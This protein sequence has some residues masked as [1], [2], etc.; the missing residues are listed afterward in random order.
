MEFGCSVCEYTSFKKDN[1]IKHINRRK[2]CGSGIKEIIE[3]P[4]EIKCDFCNKNF[5]NMSNCKAHKKNNCKEKDRIKDE[6]I[7]RLKNELK[8]A[9]N[10][11]NITNNNTINATITINN[12]LDTKIDHLTDKYYNK[13]LTN[14]E[15]IHQIIPLII[16][17]IH[18]DPNV[19]ENHNIY[20]SNR[21][22]NNKHLQIF[23]NGHW[24]LANKDTEIDN[25]IND[26]ETNLS[27]WITKKG[28][29]YPEALEKLNEYLDQKFDEEVAKLVKEEVA[30]VLY[31]NRHMIRG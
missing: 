25:L 21:N 8:E 18:F 14:V 30:L 20:I 19:P 28:E 26:K 4:I 6:E 16:K 5:S 9:N 11:M 10:R 27:D 15:A 24:E 23:N 7:R 22:K 2:S 1:V 13:L 29:K 17:E 3:I 12:Y 31:N